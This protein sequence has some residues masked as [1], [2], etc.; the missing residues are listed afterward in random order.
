ML[1]F[2]KI[3]PITAA[4]KFVALAMCKDATRPNIN[5]VYVDDKNIVATDGRRLHM[6]PCNPDYMIPAGS[7]RIISNN[8]AGIIIDRIE[9]S[10]VGIFPNYKMVI[11]GGDGHVLG[12]K[13]CGRPNKLDKGA[14]LGNVYS[15]ILGAAAAG[16]C[17][18][19]EYLAQALVYPEG[20]NQITVKD[21]GTA[22][23]LLSNVDTGAAAVI[24]P[25]RS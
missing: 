10:A 2:N 14:L 11:P 15:Q 16:Y 7:Y 21:T 13:V 24:M 6:I 3:L 22:T 5:C 8:A 23:L 25:I 12:Y 17:L 20:F 9:D 18:N 19:T 4:L 1:E